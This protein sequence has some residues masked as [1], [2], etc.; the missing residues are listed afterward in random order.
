M[1]D[2]GVTDPDLFA[3]NPVSDF[4]RARPWYEA[5]FGAE[6]SLFAHETECIW[7][8]AEHRF[9]YIV[10]DP[11]RAGNAI[12]TLF[13]TD[14]EERVA[15]ISG[16]GIEPAERETYSNGVRKVT[17]RDADDNELG[18]GGPPAAD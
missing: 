18:F 17:Y 7:E 16:R 10:E 6:P 11:E 1:T 12:S 5:L 8:V 9:V 2:P 13:V 14:L 4:E 15:E 3:G